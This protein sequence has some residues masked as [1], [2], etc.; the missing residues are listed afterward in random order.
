MLWSALETGGVLNEPL[1]HT[2]LLDFC[3]MQ[4]CA[5]VEPG[6]I[7]NICKSTK[8][9]DESSHA[10]CPGV[11]GGTFFVAVIFFVAP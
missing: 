2:S 5:R 7:R 10:R 6:V 1:P 11:F 8:D 4:F 9:K 3:L